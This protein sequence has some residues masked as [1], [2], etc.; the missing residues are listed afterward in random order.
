MKLPNAEDAVI[1]QQKLTDY[2]LSKGHPVGRWKAR[3]FRS[4][5]FGDEH[6]D[7][8]K[9]ALMIIAKNGEVG[10]VIPSDY[11]TKYVVEGWIEAPD[12]HRALVRT[13]WVIEA[14]EGR[15]KLV[16]VYPI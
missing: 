16:T 15:P 1:S 5:G 10:A 7:A 14:G 8:L 4:L 11:G 13:V 12:G 6:V 3:F 9:D 2:L